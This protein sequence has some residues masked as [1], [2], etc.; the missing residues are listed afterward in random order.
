MSEFES[1]A[2]GGGASRQF[3]GS[4]T[5]STLSPV[6][7]H[8]DIRVA[9]G[10]ARHKDQLPDD[11]NFES[12]FANLLSRYP[13]VE[14]ISDSEYRNHRQR[15]RFTIQETTDK[16]VFK[17]W[18]E[19]PGLHVIYKGHARYGRG[20]CF[21]RGGDE[22]LS[23]SWGDGNPTS[24]TGTFRIGYPFVGAPAH[25]VVDHGYTAH[26]LKESAGRPSPED[27]HPHLR[28]KRASLTARTLEAID[29]GLVGLVA[30]H[31]A[32]DKYW[33]YTDS[34]SL[35]VVHVAGWQD[36]V[37]SP[38]DWGGTNVQCRV[39]CL[40]GCSSFI[41]N[42][43]VVRRLANWRREGNERYAYWMTRPSRSLTYSRWLTHLITYDEE[44]AF[45]SWRPS[46]AYAVERTNRDLRR[47]GEA[48]RV[49]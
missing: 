13:N 29:P 32:G 9:H 15:V 45:Q 21:G 34:G 49:I 7:E 25:E 3:S 5:H 18:L 17:Q 14:K 40:F 16:S 42:Y 37:N 36:S 27:C 10:M 46:L 43:P 19:T 44:N 8:R 22:D 41:H 11:W 4:T 20:P 1:L 12:Y 35:H 26:L 28:P 2:C 24:T 6:Y 39:F 33:T 23:Q 31:T 48:F 47:M 30:G 38:L